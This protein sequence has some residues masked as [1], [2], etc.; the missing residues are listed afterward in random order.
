MPF[1][2]DY[3]LSRYGAYLVTMNGDPRKPVIAAAQTY[4]A[5]K[6]REAEVASA[7]PKLPE[8][9]AEALRELL[10]R[11]EHE[12]ILKGQIEVQAA[13]IK[14]KNDRLM[15]IAPK[16]NEWDYLASADGSFS[17]AV[18]AQNLHARLHVPLGQ[19]RL[20]DY[21]GKIGW[22]YKRNPNGRWRIR[23][24]AIEAGWLMPLPTHRPDASTGARVLVEPQVRV[25][26]EGLRKL[27]QLLAPP[28]P[29]LPGL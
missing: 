16:A 24:N 19:Q 13:E 8:T 27:R 20:F 5:I 2:T 18:A 26:V 23:Q 22:I 3:R 7:Q 17:V 6:T 14:G 12:E 10:V 21:M 28:P 25:T 29:A 11:V 9:Y 4:F 1:R 15:E